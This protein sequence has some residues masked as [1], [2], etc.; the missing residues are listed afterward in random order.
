MNHNPFRYLQPVTP[1]HFVGRWSLVHRMVEDLLQNSGDS[2]AILAGPRCGKTSLLLALAEQLR[3]AS[4]GATDARLP[5]PIYIDL[6]LARVDSAEAVFA[7]LLQCIYR[8]VTPLMQSL[9][10]TWLGPRWFEQ[11]V[12]SAELSAAD[13]EE[14][15]CYLLNQFE[16][17]VKPVN[18]ILLVDEAG[19]SL[20]Q[21]WTYTLYNQAYSL[22][23]NSEFK[24]R[25]HLV[26]ASSPRF[27]DQS[28]LS[29]LPLCGILKLNWLQVFG[30]AALDELFQFAPDLSPATQAAIRQQSGGHPFLAQYLLYHVWE[31]AQGMN[32]ASVEPPFIECLVAGFL[33]ERGFELQAWMHSLDAPDLATYQVLSTAPGWVAEDQLFAAVAA[34]VPRVQHALL[35]LCTQGLAIRDASWSRFRYTGEIFRRVFCAAGVSEPLPSPVGRLPMV[36]STSVVGAM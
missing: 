15:L 27:L 2:Q 20:D 29:N 10:P 32:L 17:T 12:Y 34:P 1:E 7:F 19:Q 6:Q 35:T 28:N 22:L 25:M 13:F 18:L 8:Q 14:C 11:A 24:Q 26:L 16:D 33:Y 23:C 36:I 9:R 4:S 5:L 30:P 31:E 21:P 3:L